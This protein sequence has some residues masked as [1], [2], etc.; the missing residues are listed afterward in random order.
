[1]LLDKKSKLTTEQFTER[2]IHAKR[3]VPFVQANLIEARIDDVEEIEAW[4]RHLREHGVWANEPV[5]L[6]PYPGSPDYTKLWGSPDDQAWERAHEHYLGL[7]DRYSEIQ[8][9]RPAPLVE[10]ESSVSH[11]Y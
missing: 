4:R 9:A 1:M 2:L 6:F 8:E 7:F 11:G 3:T 5:P 10:L